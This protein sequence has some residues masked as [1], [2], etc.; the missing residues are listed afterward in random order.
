LLKAKATRKTFCCKLKDRT[1]YVKEEEFLNAVPAYTH[2][3]VVKNLPLVVID[4]PEY[5]FRIRKVAQRIYKITIDRIEE[6]FPRFYEGHQD[7]PGNIEIINDIIKEK[8]QTHLLAE[9]LDRQA[10]YRSGVPLEE[11]PETPENNLETAHPRREEGD[12]SDPFWSEVPVQ[13][14]ATRERRIP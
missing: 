13:N 10:I 14:T 6:F 8:M 1:R 3:L 2:F 7:Y 4:S 11:L 5:M 9:E 12:N